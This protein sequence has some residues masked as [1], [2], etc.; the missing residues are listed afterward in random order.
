MI[1]QSELT[2]IQEAT[3]A[4]GEHYR[5]ASRAALAEAGLQGS[6]WF[7]AFIS[8]THEPALIS[9]NHL[10]KTIAPY[11]HPDTI[12]RALAEAASRGFLQP[13]DP[14]TYQLTPNGR[15][16]IARFFQATGAALASLP[17]I[18][19]DEE[20][21]QLVTLLNKVVAAT[22]A[23]PAPQAKPL[24]R[25]S[26]RTDPGLNAAAAVRIDQFV[27]DLQYYREDA[28]LA[29][30]Q[31]YEVDGHVWETFTHLWKDAPLT[32]ADII[33]RTKARGY[34]AEASADAI[35]ELIDQGWVTRDELNYRL[36]AVGSVLRQE[37]EQD[38][39]RNFS[40]GWLALNEVEAE[41][42]RQLL[43][44]L[45]TRLHSLRAK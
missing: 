19:P 8:Y 23:A 3:Q 10:Q 26:R 22:E 38:T 24:F 29:A 12:R 34:T 16:A 20:M 15:H 35:Q 6:D 30:W 5:A 7:W 32:L 4:F 28:H 44:Q 45:S 17:T 41:T 27:T 14:D 18:L 39:D 43:A 1:G 25:A 37:A 33:E 36:S 31:K 9:V 42:L 13:I 2:L 21:A 40:V 11:S